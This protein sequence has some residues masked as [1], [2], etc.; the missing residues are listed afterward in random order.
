MESVK[1]GCVEWVSVIV[2]GGLC[3]MGEA[4]IVEGGLCGM[5]VRLGVL[6]KERK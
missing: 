5:R 6:V 2:E 3:G 4:V 1:G